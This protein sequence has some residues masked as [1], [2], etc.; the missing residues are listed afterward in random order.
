M[1][2]IIIVAP[3]ATERPSRESRAIAFLRDATSS[4]DEE[5]GI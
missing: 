2:M 3:P 1:A 5:S 4:S